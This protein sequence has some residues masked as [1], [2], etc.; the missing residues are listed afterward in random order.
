MKNRLAY[1]NEF[2][3]NEAKNQSKKIKILLLVDPS[4]SSTTAVSI[5][6]ECKSRGI[7]IQIIDT[8]SAKLI[9]NKDGNFSISDKS[10]KIFDIN[11]ED[12]VVLTRRA[13]MSNT[14]TRDIV[15]QLEDANFF[16][17]NTLKSVMDCDNKYTTSKILMD[18]GI[19]TPKMSI[20]NS[21]ESIPNAVEEVGGKFPVILKLLSGSQGIGVSIIDSD[22]SL[23]SVLQTLWKINPTIEVLIQEKI[24]SDYDLRIHVLTRKFNSPFPNKNDS[25]IIGYMQRNKIEKDFRTN[26]SLGGTVQKT[27]LTPE[28]EKIAIESAKALGCNWCGVDLIVDKKTGKN[29]VLEVNASPGTKGLKEATGIN[30]VT[31][32]I[33]FV[34]DK[35]NWVRSKKTI[36]YK[37]VIT[38]EGIGD[39]VAKFD[40]GNGSEASSMT[41]DKA[42]L[43]PDK[44]FVMWELGNK[45]FKSKFI[46]IDD[47]EVGNSIDKRLIIELDITFLGKTY[48]NIPVSLADRRN[49]ATKFLVNRK[50]MSIIGCAISPYKT[51]MCTTFDGEYNPTSN[52]TDIYKGIK[53][54]K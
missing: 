7:K 13:I 33:D 36:G 43:S 24:E 45:K 40:T 51:F 39:M 54:Q 5:E 15:N 16:V 47:A 48:R 17:V 11:S 6:K 26:F 42:E 14:F 22:A 37:E 2:V 3:L 53:F 21:E 41:Y 27:K 46:G 12:T 19:P 52:K 32:I 20:I 50:F 31:D 28:Q 38:V 18:A 30:V 34:E 1:F 10:N 35:K 29:Y 49:K 9:K 25:E 8:H 44:K 23:K 4:K